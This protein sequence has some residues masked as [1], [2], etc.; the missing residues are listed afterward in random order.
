[1]VEYNQHTQVTLLQR[2]MRMPITKSVEVFSNDPRLSNLIE[3]EN[4]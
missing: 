3:F 4:D 2:T 1:M